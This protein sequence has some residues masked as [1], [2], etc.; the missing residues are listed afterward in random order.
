MTLATPPSIK[1]L[2]HVGSSV[3]ARASS[4]RLGQRRLLPDR[5]LVAVFQLAPA[6]AVA[7]PTGW[8]AFR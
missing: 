4:V 8:S 2:R 6:T 1:P 5:G 7:Q 3:T